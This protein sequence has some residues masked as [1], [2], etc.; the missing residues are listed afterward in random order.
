MLFD[1]AIRRRQLNEPS[2]YSFSDFSPDLSGETEM[3]LPPQNYQPEFLESPEG[4]PER[5]EILTQWEQVPIEKTI[6]AQEFICGQ[7]MDI[8]NIYD[9]DAT[10]VPLI[11]ESAN[12][13]AIAFTTLNHAKFIH[14]QREHILEGRGLKGYE[15]KIPFQQKIYE[16]DYLFPDSNKLVQYR[17]SLE[18]GGWLVTP[19]FGLRAQANLVG[20][21]AY[22][23]YAPKGAEL[24]EIEQV[25][26][27]IASTQD[28]ET[29]IRIYCDS[30]L[31]ELGLI[32]PRGGQYDRWVYKHNTDKIPS[33]MLA[34]IKNHKIEIQVKSGEIEET[35]VSTDYRENDPDAQKIDLIFIPKERI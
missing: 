9:P 24:S 2:H 7:T 28:N 5:I 21:F 32:P 15:F 13:R 19:P 6:L 20:L 31:R 35:Y 27:S 3:R 17:N 18:G 33:S 4:W 11:S 25:Y 29:S 34:D 14:S 30:F 10:N 22:G 12:N 23:V 26:A 8:C 1:K 16:K